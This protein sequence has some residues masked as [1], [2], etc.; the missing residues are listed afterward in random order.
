VATNSE[1]GQSLSLQGVNGVFLCV[2][3]LID[4][5]KMTTLL[6]DRWASVPSLMTGSSCALP[7]PSDGE[8][9]NVA[10]DT[11]LYQEEG[12]FSVEEEN[13]EKVLKLKSTTGQLCGVSLCMLKTQ[14]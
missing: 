8:T 1:E 9:S 13:L 12:V 10:L 5:L 4:M 3:T 7:A 11:L 14:E 6:S 2:S